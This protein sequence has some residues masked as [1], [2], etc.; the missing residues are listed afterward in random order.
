MGAGFG[1]PRGGMAAKRGSS[2]PKHPG[3]P[4]HDRK[5][6]TEYQKKA[7]RPRSPNPGSVMGGPVSLMGGPVKFTVHQNRFF[8]LSAVRRY[9]NFFFDY[10]AK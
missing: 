1:S 9:D 6:S 7:N 5:S 2:C 10:R 4:K 8:D 3:E